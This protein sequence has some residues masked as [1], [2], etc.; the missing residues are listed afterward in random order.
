MDVLRLRNSGTVSDGFSQKLDSR[1]GDSAIRANTEI[2]S[3]GFGY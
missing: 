3:M 1:F 2:A